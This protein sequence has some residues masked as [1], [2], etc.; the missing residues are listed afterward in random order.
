MRIIGHGV[1]LESIQQIKEE[2]DATNKNWAD[3]VYSDDERAQADAGPVHY[4]Y[5]AGRFAGKEAVVKALGTG[6]AGD[7]TWRGVEI[8]RNESGAPYVRLSDEV[9]A[10]ADSLGIKHW[11]VSISYT[12]G[13]VMASAIAVGD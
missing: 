12:D 8:L 7:I 5:F 11:L 10:L 2:L 13:L 1:D 6:F 4:R 3:E 9:R